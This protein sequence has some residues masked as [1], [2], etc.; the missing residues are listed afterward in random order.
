ME[1]RN[2]VY[3]N[4]TAAEELHPVLL[5][6]EV[7]K[8]LWA[9]VMVAIIAAS[10]T[11]VG[12]SL[13]YTPQYQTKTTFVVSVRDGSS[14][15][16]SNL[17]AAKSMANAFSEVLNS[18]VLKKRIAAEL[19]QER[20][21]GSISAEVVGETNL[22]EMR[23]TADSPRQAY[24]ITRAIM[25]NYEELA[26]VVLNN[27][28]LDVL[29]SPTVP[30]QPVNSAGATHY[31]KLAAVGAALAAA[32]FVAVRAY[33]RDTVKSVGEVETKLDTKMLAAV[34]HEKKYKYFGDNLGRKKKSIL[35]TDPTTGFAFAETF[36]K[37][38]TRIEYLMRKNNCKVIMVTSVMENEG[39]STVAANIALSMNRKK[40]SVLLIDADMKKPSLHKILGYQDSEFASLTDYL[41]GTANLGQTLLADKKRQI[42][43][44]LNKHGVDNSTELVRSEG[45]KKLL[46]QAKR[47]VDVVIIDTPPMDACPDAECLTELADAVVL[48]V[49]QDTTPARMINDAIDAINASDAMLFGCVFNNVHAADFNESYS[50]GSGGKYGY[51][52]KYGYSKYGYGHGKTS[53]PAEE[54]LTL[55]DLKDGKGFLEGNEK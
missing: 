44:V 27:I 39:K 3:V 37:L 2:S 9:I 18:D 43:L 25:R 6:R 36:K 40:K 38:R 51:Y 23:V 31:A 35:I 30:T 41:N 10:L 17:N 13:M 16:Y 53:R 29:Q 4:N 12:A 1:E 45:M 55:E 5:M 50:Y 42:G 14:T 32:L 19:S 48:V 15:V 11:Y 20:V 8:K 28:A 49:R 21:N 54:K 22:L 34:Y 7:L 26:S 47:N 46:S 24:L 52:G 33:L